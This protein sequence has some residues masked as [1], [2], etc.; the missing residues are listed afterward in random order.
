[1]EVAEAGE[2]RSRPAVVSTKHAAAADD[3]PNLARPRPPKKR[4]TECRPQNTPAPSAG[5]SPCLPSCAQRVVGQDITG[6][7]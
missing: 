2:K 1:M 7:V 4:Q 6:N 3:A 5:S